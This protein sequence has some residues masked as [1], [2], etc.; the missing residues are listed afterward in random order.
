MKVLEKFLFAYSIIA[1]TALFISFGVFSPK[2]LNLISI[3]LITPSIFYFWIR[4]TSPESTTA[5]KWS[6][7]FLTAIT[8][9]C[10]LGIFGYRLI[11]TIVPKNVD[12]IVNTLTPVPIQT[13]FVFKKATS[14]GETIGDLLT[15]TP[16]PITLLEFKGKPGIKLINVYALPTFTS[17]KISTL[18]ASQ[19]YLYLVKQGEW[20]EIALSESEM[21]WVSSSQIQEV[22]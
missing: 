10:G 13:P 22:Q 4:L 3:V 6:F 15:E 12:P 21:G 8:I 20:Y 19:T 17:K 14:S 5:E 2:P 9:L 11:Q 1:I 16:I 18:D 7:R